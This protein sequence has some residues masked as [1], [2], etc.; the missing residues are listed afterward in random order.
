MQRECGQYACTLFC[1][2]CGNE[3]IETVSRLCSEVRRQAQRT[4][5]GEGALEM[6][7]MFENVLMLPPGEKKKVITPVSQ[8]H[9]TQL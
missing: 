4:D 2:L 8:H 5:G 9:S 1:I 3:F 7:S 6:N